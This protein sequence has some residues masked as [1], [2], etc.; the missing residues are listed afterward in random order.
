MFFKDHA[1]AF[2]CLLPTLGPSLCDPYANLLFKSDWFLPL[3]GV[4][5][6]LWDSSGRLMLWEVGQSTHI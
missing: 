5:W 2:R 6:S 3:V 1:D 4:I